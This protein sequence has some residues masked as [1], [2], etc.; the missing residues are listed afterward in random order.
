[1]A[2]NEVEITVTGNDNTGS[3][4]A[5][6]R[7]NFNSFAKRMQGDADREGKSIGKRLAGGIKDSLMKGASL[8]TD[9]LQSVMSGSLKGA[10]STPIVGPIIITALLAAVSV[11]API[12]AAA[13]G[14]ALA[15]GFGAGFVGIG[16]TLL[17]QNKKIKAEFEKDWKGIQSTLTD[18]FKP[19]L[20]VMRFAMGVLKDLAN[21]FAPV[22]KSMM[23]MAQGP[24]KGF[25]KDLGAAFLELKPAMIPM[26]EAFNQIISA[27]G[28]MLPGL[29]ESIG[30]SLAQLAETMIE[31]KDVIA[32][33]FIALL[34][35]IPPVIDAIGGM[36]RFLKFLLVTGAE[37]FGSLGSTVLGWADTVL[38]AIASVLDGLAQIP[39]PMQETMR[40]AANSVRE[41]QKAVQGW[42][43]DVERM[44]KRVKL[45]AEISEL[46]GKLARAK[47]EL[48]DPNLTKERRAKLNA[49]I[50]QLQSAI[51]RAKALLAS[52][53]DRTVTLTV[54]Q[55]YYVNK[56]TAEQRGFASGGIIG[57]AAAGGP[58]NAQ[59]LVGEQ[60]PELVD[61]PL[62][63]RVTP[64]GG[65]R[66]Q[67]NANRAGSSSMAFKS[68]MSFV[69]PIE[70]VTEAVVELAREIVTLRDALTK[71]S[72]GIF[73]QE[74]ALSGY[75]AAIDNVTKSLKENKKTLSIG[76][77]KGRNNRQ[78]LMDMAEAAQEV[79]VS[80]DELNKSP[81][82]IYNQMVKMRAE[83]IKMAKS[84][85]LTSKEARALADRYG[86]SPGAAKRAAQK[87]DRDIAYNKALEKKQKA[88]AGKAG[89][90][91]AGGWTMVGE[92]GPELTRLPYG[93]SVM[94]AGQTASMMRSGGSSQP[95]QVTL[96]IG[97]K[98]LGKLL[99]D[100]LRGEIRNLGGD[101]QAV[102][103]RSN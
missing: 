80:M 37:V 10:L 34:M 31:N 99:L 30:N 36:I 90:G 22:I 66:N 35:A 51:A 13:I 94:P 68:A 33:V 26:M 96:K 78:A 9:S 100:P 69:G 59:T 63:S 48:K 16:A 93:S 55:R 56:R 43:E 73:G 75:Q 67:L 79:V 101:V 19:L 49:Q 2:D 53:R 60:G 76:T 86:L 5:R 52:V 15:L 28:P 3:L 11:A 42:K 77:E 70:Q 32:A 12:V 24:L 21:Q 39:G 81:T 95:L 62:G 84:F 8:I 97:N 20:P 23:T 103:G 72:G 64:A 41:A 6:I 85:G 18:A 1:M 45:N 38:G 65:T 88:A 25:I 58:Q 89:G 87:E 29:F 50:G 27:I 82:A 61:L 71:S 47:R 40:S 44:P 98:T 83:F 4:F 102:L 17:L 57:A 46:Q 7:G 91:P 74:R 54:M 14:G 92:Y